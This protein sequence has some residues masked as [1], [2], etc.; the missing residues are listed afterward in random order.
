MLALIGVLM[1]ALLV[2]QVQVLRGK[3]VANPDGS[4]DSWREQRI[5]F[6]IALA[7]IVVACPLAFAAIALVFVAPRLGIVLLS[8]IAFWMVWCNLATTATSLRFARPKITLV[9]LVTFP[10]AALV[11]LAFLTWM[12]VHFQ[13][14]FAT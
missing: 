4:V 10:F 14:V 9:W 2:W 6:G 5:L 12:F 3:A 13:A 11:G 1:L 8:M 7:D